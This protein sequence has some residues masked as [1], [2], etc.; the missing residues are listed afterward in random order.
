MQEPASP[1]ADALG[2]EALLA[3][4][5]PRLYR[6][7]L[8]RLGRAERAEEAVAETLARLIEKGPPLSGPAAHVH[9]WCVRCIVNVCREVGRAPRPLGFDRADEPRANSMR[10]ADWHDGISHQ[11]PD[12]PMLIHAMGQLSDRQREAVTLRVL[13]GLSVRAASE[14]MNCAEG[15]VKALT[16]Q[17]LTALRARLAAGSFPAEGAAS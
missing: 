1:R 5:A 9:G 6:Y 7:A 12:A 10:F 8:V 11:H 13:M 2:A 4:F 15:T 17:G 3:E 16:H 14:A